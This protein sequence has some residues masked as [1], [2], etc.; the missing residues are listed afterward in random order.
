MKYIVRAVIALLWVLVKDAHTE[1]AII[2]NG[3]EAGTE[4]AKAIADKNFASTM[5]KLARNVG[6]YLGMVGPVIGIL[7]CCN[8]R[9]TS[10]VRGI[11]IHA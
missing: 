5:G 7:S 10:G 8:R 1:N 4:L 3:I 9:W 6:P 2:S 11:E